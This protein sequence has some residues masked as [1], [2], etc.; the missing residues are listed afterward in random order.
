[1]TGN[2]TSKAYEIELCDVNE[3]SMQS[4]TDQPDAALEVPANQGWA[5]QSA[6]ELPSTQEFDDVRTFVAQ[7]LLAG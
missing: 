3:D 4:S 2:L 6:K 5:V 7:S 1:M